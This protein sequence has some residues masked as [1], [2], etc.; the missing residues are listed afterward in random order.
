CS[1]PSYPLRFPSSPLYF[2]VTCVSHSLAMG[3]EVE[4]HQMPC[5]GIMEIHE[6][7]TPSEGR[8]EVRERDDPSTQGGAHGLPAI[9]CSQLLKDVPQVSLNRR[10]SQ[11]EV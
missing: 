2:Q 9:R 8:S 7:P 1:I 5:V 4:H 10:G 6:A 3:A 11:T